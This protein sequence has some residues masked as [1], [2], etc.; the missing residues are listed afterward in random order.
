M[1]YNS[2]IYNKQ[3]N[4]IWITGIHAL[5]PVIEAGAV[6]RTIEVVA[7]EAATEEAETG[8]TTIAT[9]STMTK[10]ATNEGVEA[11]DV[12]VEAGEAIM[13]RIAMMEQPLP[14]KPIKSKTT[15]QNK[16]SNKKLSRC[17]LTIGFQCFRA[18]GHKTLINSYRNR[19]K[20]K[21][22]RKRSWKCRN[23][24]KKRKRRNSKNKKN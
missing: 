5:K 15:N 23:K 24:K 4:Q 1:S 17:L 19:R 21:K 16:K 13:T 3:S 6:T 10:M 18:E 9:S 2:K 7:I 22:P 14:N 20:K 8:I 11:E 12:A